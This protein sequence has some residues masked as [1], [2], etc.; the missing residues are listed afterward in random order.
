MPNNAARDISIILMVI[1][2]VCT[3][4]H[5]LLLNMLEFLPAF[6]LDLCTWQVGEEI[7]QL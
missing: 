3:L 5:S 6:Q 4:L 1:H 7:C 2:E